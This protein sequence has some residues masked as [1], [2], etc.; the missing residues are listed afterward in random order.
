MVIAACGGGSNDSTPTPSPSPSATPSPAPTPS[1][2]PSPSA[3]PDF[4][5]DLAMAHVEALAVDIGIRAAGREGEDD[6][7]QYISDEL[8]SYGYETELQPF[9]VLL[10]EGVD[11]DFTLL[12]PEGQDFVVGTLDRA[13][14]GDAEAPIIVVPGLGEPG[15]FPST[16]DGAIALIE[17]G[18][19]PFAEKVQNAQEAG[20]VAVII[21]N[22]E[23]GPIEGTLVYP[24]EIPVITMSQE[25]GERLVNLSSQ[26]DLRGRVAIEY[27][28]VDGESQ[29]VIGRMPG[30]TCR[31][32]VGG[33]HDSVPAGPGANDNGSGTAVVLEMARVLAQQGETEDVCFVLFGA[34]E[35]GLVGSR[36]YVDNLSSGEFDALE[37]MLDFDMLGVGAGWPLA[38]SQSIVDL[39]DEV[40]TELGIEIQASALPEGVGSDHAPF[41]NAG[42][43]AIIFNCFCDDNYHTA[44]DRFEFVEPQ[45]LLEA[46]RIGLGMVEELTGA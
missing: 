22:N 31:I 37:A 15:D 29:N 26:R 16:V 42:I 5:S 34:E 24:S 28:L 38:G 25:D 32:V 44:A 39:A 8:A 41:Q 9:P 43:P 36:Y 14:E 2:T 21:Y 18:V 7:A 10:L 40:A 1:P 6:A 4:D 11:I 23:P 3:G 46:G 27:L 12:E 19:L 33:H 20:A 45:R 17:R 13:A 35:I 30:A